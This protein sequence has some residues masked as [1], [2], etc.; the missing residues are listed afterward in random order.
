[1][2]LSHHRQ[3]S[4]PRPR[5]RSLLSPVERSA[6]RGPLPLAPRAAPHHLLRQQ[7]RAVVEGLC[8][9]HRDAQAFVAHEL[10]E[11]S[12]S[13]PHRGAAV[14]HRC[15]LPAT[16]H[17]GATCSTLSKMSTGGG[18]GGSDDYWKRRVCPGSF[19]RAANG[20]QNTWEQAP[21]VSATLPRP[22]GG[23]Q[24]WPCTCVHSPTSTS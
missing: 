1:M 3:W 13:P 5:E 6:S 11:P 19:L 18:G 7:P 14:S 22:N 21:G 8:E 16:L 20:R 24:P 23:G 2:W 15:R 10:P 17:A 4:W 12:L 9:G